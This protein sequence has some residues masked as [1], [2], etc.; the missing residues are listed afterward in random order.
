MNDKTKTLIIDVEEGDKTL[1]SFS[2]F[3]DDEPLSDEDM[4]D[5]LTLSLSMSIK[6]IIQKMDHKDQAILMKR[7]VSYLEESF[8]S[9]EAF[10]DLKKHTN[11]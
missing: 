7:V 4:V 3:K 6:N 5:V 11:E 1:V 2:R 8:V 9:N 10:N